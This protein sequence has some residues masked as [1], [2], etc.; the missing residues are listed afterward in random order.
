MPSMN[1]VSTTV[2][3]NPRHR[4]AGDR[5][6]SGVFDVVELAPH[7]RPASGLLDPPG[8]FFQSPEAGI[9]VVLRHAGEM[10]GG[11]GRLAVGR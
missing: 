6:R 9:A 7:V 4:L 2:V 8:F 1:P 11:V 3:A 10:R 5:R